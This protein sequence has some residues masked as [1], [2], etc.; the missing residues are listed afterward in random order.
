MASTAQMEWTPA[1]QAILG[2]D[3]VLTLYG[4]VSIW[5]HKLEM[6]R[7]EENERMFQREPAG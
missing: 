5:F 6:F 7:R 1:R 3:P 4:E 2:P